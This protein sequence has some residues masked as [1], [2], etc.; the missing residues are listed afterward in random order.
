MPDAMVI[1]DEI[2]YNGSNQ[3]QIPGG[4][5]DIKQ[6]WYKGHAVAVKTMWVGMPENIEKIRKVS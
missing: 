6:G 2:N 3:R 4:Y 1:R 5:A